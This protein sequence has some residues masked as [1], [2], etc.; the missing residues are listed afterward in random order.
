[1]L[2]SGIGVWEVRSSIGVLALGEDVALLP[3]VLSVAA[4]VI[5][6][7]CTPGDSALDVVNMLRL[8]A[9]LS[10]YFVVPPDDS[11]DSRED[12]DS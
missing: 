2:S 12:F 4:G 1:M 7:E 9:D 8:F 3:P 6:C 11:G 5:D 10:T